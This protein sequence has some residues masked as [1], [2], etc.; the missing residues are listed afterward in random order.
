MKW[1]NILKR[2]VD[3]YEEYKKE[4]RRL[5]DEAE[6]KRKA[7]VREKREE[8][9][10]DGKITQEHY[11]RKLSVM[12]LFTTEDFEKYRSFLKP[13]FNLY[14]MNPEYQKRYRQERKGLLRIEEQQR[15]RQQQKDFASGAVDRRGKKGGRKKK[16]KRKGQFKVQRGSGGKSK[17]ER[18]REGGRH[19][20]RQ[21]KKL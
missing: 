18:R 7:F 21:H 14:E 1:M 20:S 16:K 15:K 3:S 9:L 11:M 6:R 5:D 12:S 13:L 17:S 10:R 4:R 8:F 2:K 19:N